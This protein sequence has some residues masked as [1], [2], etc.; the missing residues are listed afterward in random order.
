MWIPTFIA[1]F[2]AANQCNPLHIPTTS[3]AN[4][5]QILNTFSSS[6]SISS[7]RCIPFRFPDLNSLLP[8]LHT[9]PISSSLIWSWYKE[10]IFNARLNTVERSSAPVDTQESRCQ[11]DTEGRRHPCCRFWHSPLHPQSTEFLRLL[12][13]DTKTPSRSATLCIK[14]SFATFCRPLH[15]AAAAPGYSNNTD[16]MVAALVRNNMEIKKTE[17]KSKEEADLD[18][19]QNII[20]SYQ[21][22]LSIVGMSTAHCLM[23]NGHNYWTKQGHSG[24]SFVSVCGMSSC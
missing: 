9:P 8:I 18:D 22:V 20:S 15:N 19:K 13:N 2:I 14:R 7:N 17:K 1:L 3:F 10:N 12:W 16:I 5:Q 21:R 24:T 4:F 6:L 23:V 11:L